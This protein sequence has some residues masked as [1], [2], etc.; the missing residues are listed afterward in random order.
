M[1]QGG[2]SMPASQPPGKPIL[3]VLVLSRGRCGSSNKRVPILSRR[4]ALEPGGDHG[5]GFK[6]LRRP[7]PAA[8]TREESGSCGGL[9]PAG[10]GRSSHRTERFIFR[11]N[12]MKANVVRETFCFFII[13][14]RNKH[15]I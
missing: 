8:E 15:S 14:V 11:G 9:D 12:L 7:Q 3:K 6:I 2:H 5:L 13:P 4:L 1:A 10:L